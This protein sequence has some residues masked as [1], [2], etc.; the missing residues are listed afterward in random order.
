MQDVSWVDKHYF[1]YGSSHKFLLTTVCEKT[2]CRLPNIHSLSI[3]SLQYKITIGDK[4]F[5]FTADAGLASF[6][7][8]NN[9]SSILNDLYW[10]KL[11]HHGSIN[12]IN[13]DFLQQ[14]NPS[15]VFIST[16]KTLDQNLADCLARHCKDVRITAESGDLSFEFDE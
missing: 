16:A 13:H 14:M 9:S 12:N 11:P 5:L 1:E 4:K 10:L 3:R 7:Q 6:E 15:S 2:P 8:I